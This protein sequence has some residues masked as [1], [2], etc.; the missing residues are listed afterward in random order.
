L[1]AVGVTVPVVKMVD[2]AAFCVAEP[3]SHV[4]PADSS[5]QNHS[6]EPAAVAVNAIE[7]WAAPAMSYEYRPRSTTLVVRCVAPPGVVTTVLPKIATTMTVPVPNAAPDG[8][9]LI[10][11]V[12]LKVPLLRP[13]IVTA[14]PCELL[15]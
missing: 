9:T 14:Q 11:V 12:V 8:V 13:R 10:A 5:Q 7:V 6:P 15:I 4:E 3:D 1:P 2:A